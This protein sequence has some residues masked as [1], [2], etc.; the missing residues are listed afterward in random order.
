MLGQGNTALFTPVLPGITVQNNW[1][2]Q[3]RRPGGVSANTFTPIFVPPDPG[4]RWFFGQ[5]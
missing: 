5:I 2:W 3:G 1:T 4:V